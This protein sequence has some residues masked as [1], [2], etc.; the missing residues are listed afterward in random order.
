M[1]SSIFCKN[2]NLIMSFLAAE[3]VT[4]HKT[5]PAAINDLLILQLI[6]PKSGHTSSGFTRIDTGTASAV[7]WKL[8][9]YDL[10]LRTLCHNT[11]CLWF[12]LLRFF[13]QEM[14]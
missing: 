14:H 2:V 11:D 6:V 10:S 4:H 5:E 12:P 3:H 7:A 13:L 8:V 9:H 1:T